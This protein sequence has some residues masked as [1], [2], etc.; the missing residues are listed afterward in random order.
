MPGT[1]VAYVLM[2]QFRFQPGLLKQRQQTNVILS[3]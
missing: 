1:D 3:P 2:G